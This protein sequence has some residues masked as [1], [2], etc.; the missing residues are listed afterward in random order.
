MANQRVKTAQRDTQRHRESKTPH[1]VRMWLLLLS[2]LLF[3]EIPKATAQMP[4]LTF[5]GTTAVGTSAAPTTVTLA[6]PNGGT[7]SSIAVFTGGVLNLDFS[8]ATVTPTP[9]G[10]CTEGLV[11]TAGQ[12]CT[13]AIGF[14]PSFPGI[15]QGAVLLE[16]TDP[17][18]GA[19]TVLATTFVS[20]IGLGGLPVLVPGE[21]NTVAGNGQWVYQQD[22][23]QATAAS[24]FL[25]TGLAV[26]AAG[27]LYLCDS[28][29][30][31]IRRVDA[32]SHVISTVAGNGNPGSSGDGG[33]STAAELDNPSGLAL[34]GAGNLYIAD[35]GNNVVRRVDAISG[36]IHTVAGQI[37]SAG[38]SGD[39]HAATSAKLS[40][41]Q[42]LAST[43]TGDLVIADSGNNV[44][45][46]LSL[47]SGTIGSINTIAGTGV[48]G[49]SGDGRSA[50]AASLKD[51]YGVAVRLDGAIAI[52]DMGN[53]VVRLLDLSGNINTVAGNGQ[54]AFAGDNGP[55]TQ[56]SLNTPAAVAFDPA[57][58]LF[59]GDA[60]NNRVRGIFGSPGVIVTLTGNSSTQF[61][62]DTGPEDQASLYGP[63]G[64]LFDA[65]GNLWISD[66]F[67]NR[68]REVTGSALG[69]SYMAMKVG[70]VS[71][72]K[73]GALYNGGNTTL[74]L[75][76]PALQQA[77]LDPATT[78]C[79]ESAMAPMAFCNMGIDFAPT[80]VSPDATGSITWP[81]DAHEISP[82]DNLSGEVLSVEPTTTALVANPSPGLL[83]QPVTLMATVSSD[84]PSFSGTVSFS[85]GSTVYCASAVLAPNGTATCTISSLSL[86]THSFTATYSGDDDDAASTSPAC[87]EVV[88][89]VPELVLSVSSNPA[90]V[91]NS[92]TLMLTAQ[93][94]TNIPTGSVTFLDGTAQLATVQLNSAGSAT[95]STQAFSVGT[96][97]LSAAYAGDNANATGTSNTI[98]EQITQAGTLTV[99]SSSNSN[100]TVGTPVL[101]TATV[102]SNSGPA[103]TGS[104]EFTDGSGPGAPVLG[105]APLSA[106]GTASITV[107]NLSP[108]EHGV[109]ATYS[110]DTDSATSSARALPETVQPIATVT[111]LGAD[112]NPL[113]A[114]ASLHLTAI[115]ALAPGAEADGALLGAVTF[116][117]GSAVLGSSPMNS[118]GQATLTVSTLSVGT[119]AITATFAGATNYAASTSNT[120]NEVVQE[121]T[122]QV[123]LSLGASSTLVGKTAVFTAT[124]SSYTGVPT[125]T[126]TF[127]D[128][129]AL[130][131][132]TPLSANGTGGFSTTT[133]AV[134]THTITAVYAGDGNYFPSTSTGLQEVV[135]LAQPSLILSGPT[136][137]VDAGTSTQ[138][139]SALTSPGLS[140]TGTISL[141]DGTAVL[142]SD[143]VAGN[144]N[145]P[146][147]TATLRVGTHTITARYGGDPNTAASNSTAILV[148]VKQAST[149]TAL[150]SSANPLTLNGALTLTAT[151][152]TD[153]PNV[154]G[155]VSF[156]DG[157]KLLGSA[158]IGANGSASISP[159]GLG[160]GTH[161]LTAAY[162]GDTNHAASTSAPDPELVVSSASA[163]LT[164]SNNPAASGQA[165]VFSAQVSGAGTVVPSG[166]ITF[167]D[168]GAVLAAVPLNSAGSAS[169]STTALSVG[170]H[171]ITVTYPGDQNFAAVGAQLL[172]TVT[173]AST[174]V[175]LTVSNNPATYDQPFTF[176]A[177]VTSDGGAATGTVKFIDGPTLIGSAQLKTGSANLTLSKLAPGAHTVTA[178]YVGDGKA[179]PSVSA[180]L[181]FI[182]KQT[183]ALTV[184]SNGNPAQT[185]SPVDLIATIS[186]AGAAPATG[187]V[188]FT[189]G[190]VVLGT[191][192][193][194]STGHATLILPEMTAGTHNISAAYAG[195]GDNFG[196]R[197]ATFGQVVQL[198]PTATTV[199]GSSTDPTNPQQIT[200]I[201]VVKGQGSTPPTGTVT[202]T[203]GSI[204]L[205]VAAIDD[206]GV[207]AIT[208][209]FETPSEPV[210]ASYTGDASY[211]ASQ[212]T[213]TT[214]TAGQAAQFTLAVDTPTITL[215]SHQHT[216][217]N[218]TLG[219]V[220]GFTDTVSIGCL[221]LPYAATCTFSRDQLKLE[222]NGTISASLI[223]DTGDP[224]GAG[225]GTTAALHSRSGTVLCWLPIGLLL[226]IVRRRQNLGSCRKLGTLLLLAMALGL[227]LCTTG[228]S[229]LST[230]G[231]PPGT[232]TFKV[233]G[234]GQGS[235]TTQAQTV[236][237]V[238]TQ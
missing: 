115:V 209:V 191:E 198:R 110:G 16:Q 143:T 175:A 139:L 119:H 222:P 10:A 29:N 19:T 170:S 134:G 61:S 180:A 80:T 140:P 92:V 202:F 23:V 122:T 217:V 100:P 56:A 32:I 53:Q 87:T 132:S 69:I 2:A 3:S 220:K 8:P 221:G 17:S 51:P 98:F 124:V 171:T 30:N 169:F 178:D 204:T 190:T 37:G 236:T 211:T 194:D 95:W 117:D 229:G 226:G 54:S 163:T 63:Y 33:K 223:L 109:V 147:A 89:Q 96:H 207:A 103:P 12:S 116:H 84:S 182:V 22:N 13:V 39:G 141:L 153:S 173:D 142:A 79:N 91:T 71:Q 232:Y 59:I 167:R 164:S 31:R 161:L 58:D 152:A 60:G 90:V 199:T 176:T 21:I 186:N 150:V 183:T 78:T 192:P 108:G 114:G 136:G 162:A 133:L 137:A 184:S 197:S 104:V 66:M 177:V 102:V 43:P 145:F 36:L 156:Y 41:P 40:S 193:L 214:I 210:I 168:N 20:G 129:S 138:F 206:T 225:T 101:F 165:V 159:A 155:T 128:G 135:Q 227:S 130:L 77:A 14:T 15:R 111:S 35:S 42:G 166:T 215:A 99:L 1:G 151:V 181:P 24:I 52:A 81:S 49:Y 131:G 64:L 27:D 188:S 205:G 187:S 238:V 200:L 148:T 213:N 72:P 235:G 38:Y 11:L 44:I 228:C 154:G 174:Q 203:T 7:V 113:S 105:S 4:S 88:K 123:A 62:G 230:S 76:P 5:P 112:V 231:T 157:S 28:S 179:S 224:L 26:D 234:T 48:A 172:Q 120:L 94:Q 160:L 158:G 73:E 237:L 75:G 118:T 70:K 45:R 57:G 50:T 97:N 47:T 149:T 196:S 218:V 6:S 46:L 125:G 146:F 126:I 127:H 55:A 18:T 65:G 93:D 195:D 212:S 233:V 86:G 106:S 83:G 185:L 85:E 189:D 144:G 201:A 219:S 67:H 74:T 68:V 9:A 34:D 216:T 107:S 121:T 82:V 208:V 25:P